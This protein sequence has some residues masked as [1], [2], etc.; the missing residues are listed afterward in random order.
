M[1]VRLLYQKIP[2]RI[3]QIFQR[4]SL[5]INDYAVAPTHAQVVESGNQ[6]SLTHA[7]LASVSFVD[8][9]VG[10]KP[11]LMR[12]KTVPMQTIQL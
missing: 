6:R 5:T 1:Q 8:H 7:Y 10:M 3:L 9:C 12:L 4:T 11:Y 2:R